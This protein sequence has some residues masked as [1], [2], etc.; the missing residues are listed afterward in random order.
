MPIC[1]A[2]AVTGGSFS[3]S[4]LAS[5]VPSAKPI[6]PHSAM[7]MPGILAAL[8][9][10]PLPPRIEASPANAITSAI[11]RSSVGRSPSTGQASIAAH[12]GMV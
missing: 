10:K 2:A 4:F 5:T 11:V 1:Q 9:L 7:M 8:A 3:D 6:A 12:T